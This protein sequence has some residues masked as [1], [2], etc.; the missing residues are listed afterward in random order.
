MLEVMRLCFE[1][2]YEKG[3]INIWEYEQIVKAFES[4][5]YRVISNAITDVIE[6][7]ING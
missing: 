7:D 3:V 4:N 6:G 1:L 5:N 2:L